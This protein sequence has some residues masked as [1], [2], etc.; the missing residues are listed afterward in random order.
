MANELAAKLRSGQRVYGTMVTTSSPLWPAM[1][2]G[3]GLDFVFIDTEHVPLDRETASWMCRGYA[4][5][6]LAPIVRVGRPCPTAACQAL[7][8]GA[9]GVVAPYVE[10]A[11]EVRAMVGAVKHRPVKGE[12]L[13]RILADAGQCEPALADY[14]ESRN[15]TNL[16][17]VNIESTP[18]IANLDEI[19]A[20]RGLDVVLIGPHDLSCSLGVPE[21][22]DHPRFQEAVRRI[23]HSSREAGVAVGIHM[24]YGDATDELAWI[25]EGCNFVLHSGDLFL[26][27]RALKR[28]IAELQRQLGDALG[29]SADCQAAI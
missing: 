15:A 17:A 26:V 18:A 24:V 12:R 27:R 11:D 6:G 14:L 21:Q 28:D 2:Q 22:Y 19:L 29:E 3:V 13:K 10:S 20:V 9:Q 1:L 5:L 25:R 4:A 7:D 8:G 23:I 16:C